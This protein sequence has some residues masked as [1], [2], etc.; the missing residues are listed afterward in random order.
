MV[1]AGTEGPRPGAGRAQ[2]AR[3]WEGE[4]LR[5]VGP[6]AVLFLVWQLAEQAGA[7]SYASRA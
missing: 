3:E 5:A 4:C 7:V 6:V 1:E 2:R